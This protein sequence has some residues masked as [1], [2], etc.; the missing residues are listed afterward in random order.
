[1]YL[2]LYYNY[3]A[4]G[5]E[6]NLIKNKAIT[7]GLHFEHL[8]NNPSTKHIASSTYIKYLTK[9]PL[10][11]LFISWSTTNKKE[12][13]MQLKKFISENFFNCISLISYENKEFSDFLKPTQFGS[14]PNTKI[15]KKAILSKKNDLWSNSYNY[16]MIRETNFLG[17]IKQ[18]EF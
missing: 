12:E 4:T 16:K 6:L 17:E 13:E 14:Q 3:N 5:L 9:L 2:H 1:M 10:F 15:L 18:L 8:H 7:L 11:N